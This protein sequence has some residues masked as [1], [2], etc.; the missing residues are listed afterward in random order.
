M[1]CMNAAKRRAKKAKRRQEL[2]EANKAIENSLVSEKSLAVVQETLDN[3]IST[4]KE[5]ENHS[6]IS[7]SKT[8]MDES[9][10]S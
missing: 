2:E 9:G 1:G 7:D 10:N 4:L 8:F 5:E 3:N 6:R